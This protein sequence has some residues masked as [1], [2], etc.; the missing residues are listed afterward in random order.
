MKRLF[1]WLL[2]FTVPF[3]GCRNNSVNKQ[4]E[5]II[6]HAGS[7]SVP[8]KQLAKEYEK[9]NPGTKIL[10]EPAG[11]LVCAR[12]ITELKKPCDI[13]ASADYL[14]IDELIVPEYAS[15]S[16]RFATN[17]IVIAFQEKSKY[18]SEIDSSN[19]M[20]ILLRNDVTYARSDPDSDPCGYR[21]VLTFKLA[22]KYYRMPGLAN[23][24]VSKN[25]DF[26]RPKE[27]DLV[28]LVEA[29]AVDYMF[30]YKSVAIQHGLKYIKLPD[31]INLGDP[32]KN[33]IYNSVSLDVT[34]STPGSKMTVKGDYINY[35]LSV[36]SGAVNKDDA[37]DFVSF[38]LSS[39]GMKIFRK[40]GQDP[41]VPF[42]TEQPEMIP[43]KLKKY[44][45]TSNPEGYDDE[46]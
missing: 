36:L 26:I 23:K 4:K 3:A 13:I 12:K 40:N 39:E 2:I 46:K 9:R 41:I 38:L 11:S 7:L 30:Q 25:K 34:G 14:V 29:N 16:I 21:S 24:L 10:M 27:V 45:D 43:E 6:F 33:E 32:A 15:W 42:S 28:A 44:L 20:D 37:V 1:F 18:S 19:W 17:E 5:I 31:Y 22:E 8:F 35:S